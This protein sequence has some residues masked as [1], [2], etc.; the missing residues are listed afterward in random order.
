M[1]YRGKKTNLFTILQIP[2]FVHSP[3]ARS[4]AISATALKLSTSTGATT[5]TKNTTAASPRQPQV[6]HLTFNKR[7][8]LTCNSSTTW[9][10]DVHS[11]AVSR[12]LNVSTEAMAGSPPVVDPDINQ[13]TTKWFDLPSSRLS[14]PTKESSSNQTCGQQRGRLG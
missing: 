8:D 3:V 9:S 12:L 14:E 6:N 11:T 4:S 10:P 7:T 5:F 2:S 1:M 13:N